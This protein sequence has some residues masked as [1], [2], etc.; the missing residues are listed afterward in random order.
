MS[1]P[2]TIAEYPNRADDY[3]QAVEKSHDQNT[4]TAL[5]EGGDNEV[6]AEDIVGHI[7]NEENPHG[8][9][10]GQVGA[11]TKGETG[12]LLNDKADQSALNAT[13]QAVSALDGRVDTAE[14]DIQGLKDAKVDQASGTWPMQITGTEGGTGVA[15][16]ADFYRIGNLVNVRGTVTVIGSAV[17]EIEGGFIISG[18]QYSGSD[19][20]QMGELRHGNN[21]VYPEG[22]SFVKVGISTAFPGS[23]DMYFMGAGGYVRINANDLSEGTVWRFN[24]TYTTNDPFNS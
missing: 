22:A 1:K 14:D 18:L 13:N 10:A 24:I 15:F 3:D 16:N 20:N 4:D 2:R 5:D 23:L 9:T 6:T 19:L 8:T 12:D 17:E 11:Y 21:V 7:E